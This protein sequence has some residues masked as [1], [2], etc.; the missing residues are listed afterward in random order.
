MNEKL[1]KLLLA[2]GLTAAQI[3]DLEA[4]EPTMDVDASVL[5][6]R[7]ANMKLLKN[8]ADFL[9][10]IQKAEK[11]KNLDE[12][13]RFIKKTFGL[14]KEEIKDKTVDEIITIA[15]EKATAGQDKTLADLQK[16]NVDLKNEVQNLKDVEIPAI[17]GEVDTHKKKFNVN[18]AITKRL[19]ELKLRNPIEVVLAQLE[20]EFGKKYDLDVDDKGVLKIVDKATK[21]EVRNADG[22]KLLTADEIITDTL[23][24]YK[25]LEESGGDGSG[26]TLPG[27]KPVPVKTKEQ[28]EAESKSKTFAPWMSAA[29][30]HLATLKEAEKK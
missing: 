17:R 16:E 1:K 26:K 18:N 24:T 27:V 7:E 8:D 9:A 30:A 22:T 19:A 11:G 14:T 23:S 29:E 2:L 15:K 3:L 5:A 28:L 21:L 10:T 25:F 20:L 4:T 6:I 12:F 13:E